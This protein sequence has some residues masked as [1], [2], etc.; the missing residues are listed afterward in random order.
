MLKTSHLKVADNTLNIIQSKINW[1][2]NRKAYLFGSIAPDFNCV[3]PTHTIKGTFKRFKHKLY[4]ME[5]SGSNLVKSFTLGVITHYI[6]DYF[7]YA[8]NLSHPNPKHALYERY[9]R[10]HIEMHNKLVN[11]ECEKLEEQWK[12]IQEHIIESSNNN[13]NI[14]NIL[15]S[16]TNGGFDHI[17]YIMELVD[18]MHSEYIN[19][20][21]NLDA[22]KWYYSLDKIELDLEYATFMCEKIAM[23]ILN[24]NEIL[25][26]SV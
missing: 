7:C 23:L 18:N 24:P 11:L 15:E 25:V 17:E 20:T 19:N 2:I 8:H 3:F 6:C 10:E 21:K 22:K 9:M 12:N 14:D 4:R 13:N 5:N 1:K 16:I 26:V